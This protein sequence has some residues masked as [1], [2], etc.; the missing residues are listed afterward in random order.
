MART[1]AR[2]PPNSADVLLPEVNVYVVARDDNGQ[3]IIGPDD[4]PDRGP[5]RPLSGV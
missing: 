3:P 5:H 2:F 1:R 4:R